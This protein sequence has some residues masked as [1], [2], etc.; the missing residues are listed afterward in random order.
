M[1]FQ[2]LLYFTKR[3]FMPFIVLFLV[4]NGASP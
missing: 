4:I 3:S 1:K 2:Y